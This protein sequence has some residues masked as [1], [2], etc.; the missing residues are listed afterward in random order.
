MC[1]LKLSKWLDP[2][3]YLLSLICK[4][5][6]LERIFRYRRKTYCSPSYIWGSLLWV[7]FGLRHR[8]GQGAQWCLWRAELSLPGNEIFP[9][10]DLQQLF[11]LGEGSSQSPRTGEEHKQHK[12]P[13]SGVHHALGVHFGAL[14]FWEM[15]CLYV[16]W[17]FSLAAD[18][19]LGIC[20]G[21]C[22]RCWW[23]HL[24]LACSRFWCCCQLCI[25][26]LVL[27]VLYF[28]PKFVFLWI[29]WCD[30]EVLVASQWIVFVWFAQPFSTACFCLL[31]FM[32]LSKTH[33]QFPNNYRDSFPSIVPFSRILCVLQRQWLWHQFF[34]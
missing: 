33:C 32:H 25:F 28:I 34:C 15:F 5:L 12:I 3:H 29:S 1:L 31:F 26:E 18:L 10:E 27:S 2:V 21:F 22:P 30:K 8:L 4:I 13:H 6:K 9:V 20:P 23:H 14:G 24:F 19:V 17:E 7:R 16:P 11:Q